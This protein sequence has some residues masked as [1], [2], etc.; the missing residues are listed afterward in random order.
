M[1][2]RFSAA[3]FLRYF[4]FLVAMLRLLAVSL[5]TAICYFEL[6]CSIHLK[7]RDTDAGFLDCYDYIVVGG[8]VSGLVVANR[9]TEDPDGVYWYSTVVY[10]CLHSHQSLC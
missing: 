9:L 2:S 6:V 1:F 8:G 7:G 5:C 10:F 3:W 4:T